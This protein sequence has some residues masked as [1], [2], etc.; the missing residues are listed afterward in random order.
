M[1]YKKQLLNPQHRLNTIIA[2]QHMFYL[3]IVLLMVLYHKDGKLPQV[4]KALIRGEMGIRVVTC[5][6][7]DSVV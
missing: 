5:K 6:E 7:K 2:T 1:Y 3:F 4:N